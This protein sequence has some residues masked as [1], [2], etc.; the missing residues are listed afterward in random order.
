MNYCRNSCTCL[1]GVYCI[2][3]KNKQNEKKQSQA[4]EF[5]GASG[6]WWGPGRAIRAHLQVNPGPD[7][8]RHQ[9]SALQRQHRWQASSA[10]VRFPLRRFL[11]IRLLK[12][13]ESKGW[14]HREPPLTHPPPDAP[15]ILANFFH[16]LGIKGAIYKLCTRIGSFI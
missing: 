3:W 9:R 2:F 5:S 8:A 4:G 10:T 6:V 1:K 14:G 16:V 7:N 15:P 11:Q 13:P 12:A